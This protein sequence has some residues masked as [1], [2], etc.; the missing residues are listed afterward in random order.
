MSE[1]LKQTK[2]QTSSTERRKFLWPVLGISP[3]MWGRRPS[4]MLWTDI[5]PAFLLLFLDNAADSETH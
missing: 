5:T 2:F 4:V 1:Y 3:V